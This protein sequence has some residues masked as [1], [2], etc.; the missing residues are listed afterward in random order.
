MRILK[1]LLIL[2]PLFPIQLFAIKPV[3]MVPP[4]PRNYEAY[5]ESEEI[6]FDKLLE[7]YIPAIMLQS[8]LKI[9]GV[10]QIPSLPT[11]TYQDLENMEIR[12]LQRVS[13]IAR[14]LYNMIDSLP[15]SYNPALINCEKVRSDLESKL[16]KLSLDTISLS[17][18]RKYIEILQ[19]KLA[20]IIEKSEQNEMM[21]NKKYQELVEEN[22]NLKYFGLLDKDPIQIFL[23]KILTKATQ[24]YVNNSDIEKSIY[25]TFNLNFDA[26]NIAKQRV[27]IGLWTE[28]SF[29]TT[30]VKPY[31]IIPN[32]DREHYNE[33]II[34]GGLDVGIN[35]SKFFNIKTLR[36]DFDLGVGYF[37]GFVNHANYTFPKSEYQG[38]I[39]KAETSFQNFSRL[40]PFGVHLGIYF[41]KFNEDV[42]YFTD[43]Q[44]VTMKWG[45]RPS[46]YAGISFNIIQ[47]F[48]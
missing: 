24:I 5:T 16:F 27:S 15:E 28:Y 21:F 12:T 47:I 41:N 1:Y 42:L 38:N 33:Q 45:W 11:I 3:V 48:K 30:K 44:P 14:N 23:V 17:R 10:Q 36:W 31:R 32:R 19:K 40:T 2:L 29:L 25:P 9:L 13:R 8:Q 6:Y 39:I 22:F 7:F 46:V 34:S 26:V 4:E 37:K 43:S 18:E 20:E 35:L